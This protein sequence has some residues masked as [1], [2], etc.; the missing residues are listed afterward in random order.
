[1]VSEAC[2]QPNKI[3]YVCDQC[4]ESAELNSKF[5]RFP[6]T[7]SLKEDSGTEVPK[8]IICQ[9]VFFSQ[10]YPQSILQSEL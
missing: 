1:M 2:Y 8:I 5:R 7:P 3:H 10:V 6:S 9:V 4:I